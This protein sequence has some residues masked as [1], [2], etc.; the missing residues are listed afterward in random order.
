MDFHGYPVRRLENAYIYVDF[1]KE[2]G[3]RLVRLGTAG[4]SE[5]LFVEIPDLTQATDYGEYRFFGGHRLWH[6]PEGMPR[7]Y[8]PDNEGLSVQDLADGGVKLVQPVEPGSGL[9]KSIELHL[10]PDAPRL[11]VRHTLTNEGLWLIECAPWAITQL[12]L[13]GIAI[14]PQQRAVPEPQLLPDRRLTIWNY[15][16][17]QDARLHLNDDF[18]F[19]QATAGLPPCKVGTLNSHGWAAYLC[20]DLL[21]VK[22]FDHQ[23]GARY[24]DFGC[25]TEVYCNASFIELETLGALVALQPG[26]SAVHTETWELHTGIKEAAA[27][28]GARAVVKKLGL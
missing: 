25:N 23:A 19:I 13:G 26:E 16:R 1:L 5:N 4:S 7:S 21:F 9:R 27:P 20:G 17:L 2:A 24:V 12:K 11:T 28:D 6:A 14:I 10:A 3:P 18:I 15:T 22:R 8:L